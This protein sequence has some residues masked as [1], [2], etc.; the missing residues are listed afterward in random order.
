MWSGWGGL[1]VVMVGVMRLC[2][3]IKYHALVRKREFF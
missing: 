2:G 3:E 1:V